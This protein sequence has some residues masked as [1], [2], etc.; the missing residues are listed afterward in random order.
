MNIAGGF[1]IA[2]IAPVLFYLYIFGA[3]KKGNSLSEIKTLKKR[4]GFFLLLFY[5]ALR[6]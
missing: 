5:L 4:T 6:A 1:V 2:C 3:L